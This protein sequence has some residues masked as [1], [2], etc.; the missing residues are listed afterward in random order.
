MAPVHTR[1]SSAH[2][3]GCDSSFAAASWVPAVLVCVASWRLLPPHAPLT[4]VPAPRSS[5]PRLW[6]AAPPSFWLLSPCSLGRLLALCYPGSRS[7]WFPNPRVLC[8][9]APAVPWLLL[10]RAPRPSASATGGSCPLQAVPGLEN[11]H[12][13]REEESDT[14]SARPTPGPPAGPPRKGWLLT[15]LMLEEAK[16]PSGEATRLGWPPRRLGRESGS[17]AHP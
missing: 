8:H 9:R 6:T 10:T 16:V 14:P 1:F 3:S 11:P 12:G 5:R 17:T 13:G 15:H 2:S 4:L 7:G